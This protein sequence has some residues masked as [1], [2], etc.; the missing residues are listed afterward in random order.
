MKLLSRS[1]LTVFLSVLSFAAAAETFREG[2]DYKMLSTPV[3]VDNPKNIEVREFFWFGCPHCF[4]LEAQL[5]DWKKTMPEGVDFVATPAPLNKSWKPHAHAYYIAE[6]LGKLDE[7]VPALFDVI[8]VDKKRVTSQDQLAEFFTQYG[9]SEDEFNKL[10]N[11]FSVRVNVRKAEA[12]AKTYRLTGVPAIIVNGKYLV[13]NRT[14]K[15][16]ER[17][18]EIVNFLIDKE[19]IR[20]ATLASPSDLKVKVN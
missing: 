8:H 18:I 7:I 19:K 10:Y 1:L 15:T 2:V 13:E 20:A 12:L 11:S 16:N 9:V 17:M 3:E 14:A 6:A 4:A 5:S